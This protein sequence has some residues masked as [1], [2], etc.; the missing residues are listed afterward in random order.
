MNSLHFKRIL[1]RLWAF[2][3]PQRN[4]RIVLFYH[5]VG[6]GPNAISRQ[7]FQSQMEW[8]AKNA[9]VLAL[10]DLLAGA[11]SKPMRVSIGFDDGYASVADHAEPVLRALNMP[12]TVYLNT[13]WIGEAA[14]RA[15]DPALGHYPGE[16][17]MTWKDVNRLAKRNWTIG[18]HGVEHLD[19]TTVDVASLAAELG[20]SKR[21]IEKRL[22][23]ACHHFA[24]TWGRFNKNVQSAATDAGYLTA[25]SALHGPVVLKSDLF[26]MPR[27]DIQ[28]IYSLDDFQAIVRGHWDFL[29]RIQQLRRFTKRSLWR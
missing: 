12:A 5:A 14:R 19:L 4:R 16:Q 18:S 21:T 15:S 2:A 11:G 17:F 9:N 29:G 6:G 27:I 1:G 22:D 10:D 8:L 13:G 3:L 20:D 25:A 7:L 26:A 28:K 24:Y 23:I